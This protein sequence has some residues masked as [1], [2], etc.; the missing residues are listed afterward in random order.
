MHTRKFLPVAALAA[1]LLALACSPA[2]K[3]YPTPTPT[4]GRADNPDADAARR[5]II[6]E[7]ARRY[8]GKPYK[9]A[10][11]SPETGFD[12]SG[13]TSYILQKFGVKLSPASSQQAETGRKIAFDNARP[14]DIVVFGHDGKV[15]HVALV[16]RRDKAGITCI[17]STSSRGVMEENISQS[18]YWQPLIWFAR[19]VLSG[20]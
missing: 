7:T 17:H 18:S 9:Y 2:R 1:L 19:D 15:S 10:G 20:K 12:C 8:L 13:F 11:K 3:N 6:A 14:G 16:S 4:P 5:Q